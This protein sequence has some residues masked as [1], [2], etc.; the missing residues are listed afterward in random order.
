[1]ENFKL[2]IIFEFEMGL[3]EQSIIF[4]SRIDKKMQASVD[5]KL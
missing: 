1:L 5:E 3:F 4:W 2:G